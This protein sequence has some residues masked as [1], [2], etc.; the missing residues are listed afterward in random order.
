[1]KEIMFLL[2]F[3]FILPDTHAQ[4]FTS[5]AQPAATLTAYSPSGF[6]AYRD[7][8]R[9]GA[10]AIVGG[11]TMGAGIGVAVC[12]VI[13]IAFDYNDKANSVDETQKNEGEALLAGGGLMFVGGLGMLISGIVQDHQK[14]KSRWSIVVP[15]KNEMSIVYIF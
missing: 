5:A 10:L 6:S 12:G 1:M 7:H 14:Y 3:V 15:Q 9:P 11:C 4:T 13:A 8:R 2:A